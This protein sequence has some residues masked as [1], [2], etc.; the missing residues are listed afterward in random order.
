VE[1]C[2]RMVTLRPDIRSYARVAY[3]RE[4]HGDLPGAIQAMKLAVGA[5]YAGLEQS[6]WCRAQLGRLYE[7]SGA[8]D[9]ARYCY[10]LALYNRP[11]Y[12]FALAGLARLEK[13]AGNYL[14]SIELLKKAN[15][16]I[17]EYS[18]FEE[19]SEVYK[20][21]GNN[22]L[23]DS[24]LQNAIDM[25]ENDEVNNENVK[26]HGH[27]ADRELALI[28]CKTGNY[29]QA[30]HHAILEYKRRPDNIDVQETLAWVYYKAGYYALSHFYMKSA[31]R[32]GRKNPESL[33]HWGLIK[34]K[35][36]QTAAG[37]KLLSEAI[38]HDA[39]LD[40]ELRLEVYALLPK[41]Q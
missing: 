24:A 31:M 37:K 11:D 22:P 25:L 4:I 27:Y 14:K 3:L 21:N 6:E 36:G 40:H 32:T 41:M 20:L 16:Q 34:I 2:D 7:Q 18:F 17:T 9:S 15:E 39:I 5:G 12:A 23:A 8:K 19:L 35:A 30:I 1:A 33:I 29:T 28:Y 10:E 13:S 26:G 38:E